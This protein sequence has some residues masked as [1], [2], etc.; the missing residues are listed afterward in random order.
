AA[1]LARS[2]QGVR[3]VKDELRLETAKR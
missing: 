3:A 1:V 2:I